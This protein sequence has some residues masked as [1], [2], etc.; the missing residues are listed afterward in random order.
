[1][2]QCKAEGAVQKLSHSKIGGVA[3]SVRN[4]WDGGGLAL[5]VINI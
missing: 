5:S 4:S 2:S 1:M 3:D